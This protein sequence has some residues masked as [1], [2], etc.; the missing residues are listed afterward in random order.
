MVLV[1]LPLSQVERRRV[2]FA[3]AATAGRRPA[4]PLPL[5]LALPRPRPMPRPPKP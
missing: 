4:R 5:P 2:P 1:L 3:S